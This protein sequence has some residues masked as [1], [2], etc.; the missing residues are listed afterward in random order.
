MRQHPWRRQLFLAGR[1]MTV[2]QLVGTVKVNGW[3]EDEAAKNL[4]LPVE[5]VREA[6]RY[7]NENV[8]LLTAEAEYE[9]LFLAQ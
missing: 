9:G 4:D 5:A 3:S 1:N 8:K 2:R 6:F 7:A